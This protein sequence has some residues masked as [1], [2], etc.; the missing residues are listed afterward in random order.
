MNS[1]LGYRKMID[2]TQKDVAK[3]LGISEQTYRKKEKGLKE[4][5]KTEMLVFKNLLHEK[6]LKDISIEDIFFT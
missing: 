5:N 4:F 6:G 3:I 1:V 2:K